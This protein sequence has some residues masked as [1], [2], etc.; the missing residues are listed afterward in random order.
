MKFILSFFVLCFTT[1]FWSADA[2]VQ[3]V[4]D[5][6]SSSKIVGFQKKIEFENYQVKFK[7]VIADSRC[8]K[9]VMCV[10]AGEAVILVSIYKNGDFLEDRKIRIDASGYVMESTNLA[11]DAKDFKIYGFSLSP[12][13]T[14]TSTIDEK[15]YQLEIVFQPQRSE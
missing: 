14:D 15:L 7:K 11:F 6:L 8:P 13:P 2:Q 5:S 1:F 3:I 9:N 10:R 4:K 12:Y